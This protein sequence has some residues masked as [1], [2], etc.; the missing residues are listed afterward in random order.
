M[1]YGVGI[2]DADYISNKC[3][4][5]RKWVGMLDRCYRSKQLAYVGCTVCDEWKLFSTFKSW[6]ITQKWEGMD[7]DK[8]IL[9]EGNKTYCPEY[10]VFVTK[11]TNRFLVDRKSKRGECPLGVNFKDNR[12]QAQCN[13]PFTSERDYLGLFI[14][15][16]KAH[17]AW[18]TRKHKYACL[19]AELQTD[20]RVAD[21]LRIKFK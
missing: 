17:Q 6:M 12:Y 5:Y 16:D 7:L 9:Y 1:I 20:E 10:C 21:A 18:K 15:P 8:D 4:F 14:C 11:M 2:N 19:L 13:N 3:P